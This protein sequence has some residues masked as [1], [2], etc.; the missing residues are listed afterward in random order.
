MAVGA[1]ERV[2]GGADVVAEPERPAGVDG[3]QELDADRGAGREAAAGQRH[4]GGAA[5]D[6]AAS[7]S[8]L[9]VLVIV[10]RIA[11][12]LLLVA[13]EPVTDRFGPRLADTAG[14]SSV[15]CSVTRPAMRRSTSSLTLI[16]LH[17]R[18]AAVYQ[19][20]PPVPP[21]SPRKDDPDRR[22]RLGSGEN[23]FAET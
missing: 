4:D 3:E 6:A 1:G 10:R 23:T 12:C 16:D 8:V 19:V 18:P 2:S 7:G 14:S 17:G 21:A 13:I 5:G 22:E 15:E 11:S 20:N 9:P